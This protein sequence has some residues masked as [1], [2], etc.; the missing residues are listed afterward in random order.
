MLV[1]MVAAMVFATVVLLVVG[2]SQ[3]GT[4]PMEARV[5]SLRQR[6][7]LGDMSE[8]SFLPFSD[9]VLRPTVQAPAS[10]YPT[11]CQLPSWRASKNHW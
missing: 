6:V 2:L 4:S 9:R 5:Q 8:V 3:R 10:F 11:S 7:A 1:L